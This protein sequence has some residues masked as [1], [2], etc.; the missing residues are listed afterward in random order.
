MI[1]PDKVA[2]YAEKKLKKNLR[3]RVWL[4]THADPDEFDEICHR[5]HQ[6]VFA[7]T[8]CAACRRCCTKCAGS[9][10]VSDIAADAAY[11]HMTEEEFKNR[12]LDL[13]AGLDDDAYQTKNIPCDFFCEDG[14]C[15]LGSH[16]PENCI[17]FPFTDQPDRLASLYAFIDR[18]PI[19]PA[20]YE[21]WERLKE[22]YGYRDR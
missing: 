21:I 10:P 13:E 8:D 20:A 1:S 11:L 5:L 15:A 7:H 3:F 19:C 17:R 22:E 9:I 6:E 16:K 2:Y 14:S 4:K 12:Y 18:L